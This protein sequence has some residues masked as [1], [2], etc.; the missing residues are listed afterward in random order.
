MPLEWFLQPYL[1]ITL[2]LMIRF[3]KFRL[4]AG[5]QGGETTPIQSG[6]QLSG[7]TLFSLQSLFPG[8]IEFPE[9]A[10]GAMGKV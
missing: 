6:P 1:L 5:R 4:P 8:R 10:G 3:S 9:P 7:Y 2:R